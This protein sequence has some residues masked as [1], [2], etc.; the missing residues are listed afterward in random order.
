MLYVKVS[1]SYFIECLTKLNKIRKYSYNL[2]YIKLYQQASKYFHEESSKIFKRVL[3][4]CKMTNFN[5]FHS[6]CSISYIFP[7]LSQKRSK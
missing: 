7:L 2:L 5:Y 3:F 4:F 6:G 1:S